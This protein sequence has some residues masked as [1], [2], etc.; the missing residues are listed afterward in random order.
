LAL[1]AA[2]ALPVSIIHQRW[3]IRDMDV[4]TQAHMAATLHAIDQALADGHTVYVHCWGGIG[5]TGTVVACYLKHHGLTG[6]L[7]L[8]RVALLRQGTPDS[9]RRSPETDPQHAFV[10]DFQIN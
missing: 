9:N 7:A 8:D 1:E 4:P 3:P 2:S 5:R 6:R 10:L